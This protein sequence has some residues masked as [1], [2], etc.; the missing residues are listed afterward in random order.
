MAAFAV[1][2]APLLLLLLLEP[3]LLELDDEPPEEDEPLEPLE[4]LEPPQALTPP[5][6]RQTA[7]IPA[8]VD[9]TRSLRRTWCSPP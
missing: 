3:P 7:A 2:W 4:P 1:A 8:R 9:F 6:S 5:A